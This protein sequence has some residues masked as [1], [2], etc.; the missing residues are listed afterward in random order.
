MPGRACLTEMRMP[1]VPPMYPVL[2]Q[3]EIPFTVQ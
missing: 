1:S 3:R 2:A